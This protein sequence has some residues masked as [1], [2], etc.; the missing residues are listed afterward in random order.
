[1]PLIDRIEAV[2]H[3]VHAVLAFHQGTP[4]VAHLLGTFVLIDRFCNTCGHCD[5]VAGGENASGAA[6]KNNFRDT[7]TVT[8]DHGYAACERLQA[9]LR[10][11]FMLVLTRQHFYLA[12]YG[13]GL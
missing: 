12:T 8:A 3:A 10:H 11:P 2:Q 9:D 4:G 5:G 1:M 7:T 13:E 6:I